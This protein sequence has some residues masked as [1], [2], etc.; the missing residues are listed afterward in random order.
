MNPEQYFGRRI[1]LTGPPSNTG[2]WK[3]HYEVASKITG[4]QIAFACVPI[5]AWAQAASQVLNAYAVQH[6]S[7]MA[8]VYNRGGMDKQ[9]V[10]LLDEFIPRDQQTT[11]EQFFKSH[12]HLFDGKTGMQEIWGPNSAK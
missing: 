12:A 10:S 7:V 2:S 11:V 6:L 8:Q 1:P 3:D 9:H 5:E 4:K